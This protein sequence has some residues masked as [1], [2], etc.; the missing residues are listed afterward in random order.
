MLKSLSTGLVFRNPKP[1]LR[2]V[3]AWHPSLVALPNGELLAT[4]DLGQAAESLDYHTCLSRSADGGRTWSEPQ[5]LFRDTPG[6]R[7]THSVRVGMV[8]EGTLVGFG[9]RFHRD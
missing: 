4:F 6:F 1:H 8:A 5:P 9:G 7:S 2:A 3:H